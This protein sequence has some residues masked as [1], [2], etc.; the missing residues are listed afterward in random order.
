MANLKV[1][2]AFLNL[3]LPY[4][5]ILGYDRRMKQQACEAELQNDIKFWS[6]TYPVIQK[7]IICTSS[8]VYTGKLDCVQLSTMSREHMGE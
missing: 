1:W 5:N 8:Y 3:L 4:P 6:H 2:T 7:S